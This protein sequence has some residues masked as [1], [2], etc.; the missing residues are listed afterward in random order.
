MIASQCEL[1]DGAYSILD[2]CVEITVFG[3]DEFWLKLLCPVGVPTQGN[4]KYTLHP[5]I[6]SPLCPSSSHTQG[7]IS[8]AGSLFL[9][10]KM[11]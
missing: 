5:L 1:V 2:Q 11:L 10:D 9:P 7:S 3:Y 8:R 6:Y 4:V